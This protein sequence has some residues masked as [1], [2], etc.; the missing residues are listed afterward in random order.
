MLRLQ[1]ALQLRPL[2]SPRSRLARPFR[3]GVFCRS[4][5][6]AFFGAIL[7]FRCLPRARSRLRTSNHRTLLRCAKRPFA[8]AVMLS[9]CRAAVSPSDVRSKSALGHM[10]K[11]T[12]DGHR[13]QDCREEPSRAQATDEQQH[14]ARRPVAIRIRSHRTLLFCKDN[15]ERRRRVPR[16]GLDNRRAAAPRKRF[17]DRE[18]LRRKPTVRLV[19]A[20]CCRPDLILPCVN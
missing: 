6:P 18:R 4:Q 20:A 11:A 1:P 17:D 10:H 14:I 19:A 16:C 5:A 2:D 15:A 8:E 13:E 9:R 7:K 3:T 12:A